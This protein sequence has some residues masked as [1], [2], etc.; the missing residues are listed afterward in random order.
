MQ[1]KRL[2]APF[3]GSVPEHLFCTFSNAAMTGSTNSLKTITASWRN[4]QRVSHRDFNFVD[5]EFGLIS[6][7]LFL[8]TAVRFAELLKKEQHSLI[9][10]KAFRISCDFVACETQ[11]FNEC[12]MQFV[13]N[14]FGYISLI[15]F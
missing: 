12:D 1:W 3:E 9:V 10:P 4:T 2:L 8:S 6:F 15:I 14:V 11:R 5:C 13:Y 7:I